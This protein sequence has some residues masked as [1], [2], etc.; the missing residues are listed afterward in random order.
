MY[1]KS[2]QEQ[3]LTPLT[4]EGCT[5][6]EKILQEVE[7]VDRHI[8]NH[9]GMVRSTRR[10]LKSLAK[11]KDHQLMATWKSRIDDALVE[12]PRPPTYYVPGEDIRGSEL[13]QFADE[14]LLSAPI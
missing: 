10:E 9:H 2:I 14:P 3:R 12:Q 6:I 13:F 5:R 11:I 8:W 7:Q 1:E 4:P